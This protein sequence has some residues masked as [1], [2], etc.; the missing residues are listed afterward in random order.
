MEAPDDGRILQVKAVAGQVIMA[1]E[2]VATLA[3]ADYVLKLRLPERHARFMHE[4]DAVWVAGRGLDTARSP[5]LAEGHVVRV[6]PEL[7]QGR[8]VADA[9]APGTGDYFVGERV[10]VRMSTGKRET[11]LVPE[12]AVVKREGLTFVRLE[13][14][15]IGRAHV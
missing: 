2:P 5:A 6:Y 13:G 7:D 1:G 14:R 4:G 15:E 9:V 3:T 11:I 10:R 12:T 8:V